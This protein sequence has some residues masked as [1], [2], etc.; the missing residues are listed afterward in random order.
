VAAGNY[1]EERIVV[2]NRVT[3]E[4]KVNEKSSFSGG[5][6]VTEVYRDLVGLIDA[7]IPVGAAGG[8]PI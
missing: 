6:S 7:G 8:S 4:I 2:E 5:I 1:P 3:S